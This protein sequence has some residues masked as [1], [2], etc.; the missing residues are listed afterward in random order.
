[1]ASDELPV[2]VCVDGSDEA[3]NEGAPYSEVIVAEDR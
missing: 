2:T 1:V 3:G